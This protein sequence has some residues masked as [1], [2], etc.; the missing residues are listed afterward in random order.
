[1]ES[2]RRWDSRGELPRGEGVA[3]ADFVD[4]EIAVVED[5]T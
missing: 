1:M 3:L 4:D 5:E 2:E